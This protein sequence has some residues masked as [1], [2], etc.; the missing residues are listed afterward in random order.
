[1]KIRAPAKVNLR[2]RVIGKRQDGYHLLD[3]IIVPVSLFDEI[4]IT[5]ITKGRNNTAAAE[6]PEV[7]CDHP[8]VPAGEKNLAYRA[9][10]LLLKGKNIRERVRIHIAKRIPVGA[11]LGGGSSDAAAVLLGLNRL[12]R[13]NYSLQELE[14]I[15][16]SLGA[17]V[18]FF[19]KAVPAR[20]RGIGERLSAIRHFPRLWMVILYPG[21]PLSTAWVYR[22]LRLKLTKHRLNNSINFTYLSGSP[23]EIRRLLVNDLETV[24]VSRHPKIGLLKENL[25]RAG[26]IGSLMSG[27][28]SSVFGVFD[29]RQRAQQALCRLREEGEAQAFLVQVLRQRRR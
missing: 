2:L 29:S 23:E 25:T 3:T 6:Q 11:G 17:D 13:F 19:I 27:S 22:N 7:T 5:K 8:L 12:L 28:G 24:T 15:S 14:K 26:A 16:L 10:R 21:F 4:E 20:A 9:A 18:P 1:V